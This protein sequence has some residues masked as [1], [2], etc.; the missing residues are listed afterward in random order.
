M[1]DEK[2]FFEVRGGFDKAQWKFFP[3]LPKDE[4]IETAVQIR[5]SS[6]IIQVVECDVQA[7]H[8]PEILQKVQVI[9]CS[10][11]YVEFDIGPVD[12]EIRS[13]AQLEGREGLTE[14]DDPAIELQRPEGIS[15][16]LD[17]RAIGIQ[18]SSMG[19]YCHPG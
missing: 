11:I 1:S 13:L 18:E 15:K 16:P 2:Q 6:N 10:A 14:L 19:H 9:A 7:S 4:F 5:E 3:R 12:D 17:H 8:C